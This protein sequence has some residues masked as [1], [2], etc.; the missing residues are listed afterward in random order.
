MPP[1]KVPTPPSTR[2]DGPFAL[3]R[4]GPYFRVWTAGALTNA[5]RWLEMLAVGVYVYEKTSSPL[6]VALVLF[7]RQLPQ[8]LF[9]AVLG[10]FAEIINKKTILISGLAIVTLVSTVLGILLVT[11]KAEIWHLALGAMISGLLMAMDFP[12]RR[13][14]LGELCGFDRIGAGMALDATTNNVTRMLGP[15]IGGLA[16]ETFGL[17]GAFFIGALFHAL[18]LILILPLR[19]EN[20]QS[21]KPETIK[22]KENSVKNIIADIVEAMRYVRQDRVLFAMLTI[23][24]ALNMM[25]M[26]FASMIPIIGKDELGLNAI[27]IGILASVEGCGAFIGCILISLWRTN[28]FTQ[29]FLFG[30]I[31]YLAFLLAFSFSNLYSVSLLLLFLA[32]LGH[33]GFSVGQSTLGYTK[34]HPEVR[35]RVM[36]LLS[37]TIGIQPLGILHVGLLAN[38]FG[39]SMAVMIMTAEGLIALII[40]WILWPGMHRY[41]KP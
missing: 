25:A 37:M 7:C 23:T 21:T 2:A 11:G 24:L 1:S 5:M 12:V 4:D 22:I 9:G 15:I 29:I 41:E 20:A 17:H 33:A 38:Y 18:A 27:H 40:C 14:M 3:L 16:L 34:P 6:Q 32:G 39:G 26:P 31:I 36:G 30:S 13:N 28:R 19:Y 35:G 8:V 10:T